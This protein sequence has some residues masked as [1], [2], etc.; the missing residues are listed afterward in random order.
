MTGFVNGTTYPY[1]TL[2]TDGT[3]VTS[4]ITDGSNFAGMASNGITVSTDKAYVVTFDLTLNSGDAPQVYFVNSQSGGATAKSNTETSVSGS[5]TITLIPTASE[6]VYLQ[7]RNTNGSSANF[8]TTAMSVRESAIKPNAARYLP[9][10]GHHVYNGS[11]W[12][13]EGLLAESE[14]RT[15]LLGHSE[16]FTTGNWN[17]TANITR[18]ADQAI[19][20]AGTET[21]DK[22]VATSTSG[23]H[24]IGIASSISS[25]SGN[26]VFSFYVKPSG[27][28]NIQVVLSN[29]TGS[30]SQIFNL[31]EGTLGTIGSGN[32]SQSIQDVGN[33]WYRC[34]MGYTSTK[35]NPYPTIRLLDDSFNST[36][37]GN[38]T[39]GIL[40][41]GGQ[42]ES[43]A[44]PSSYIPSLANTAN[45]VTRA[46]ETFTI[47]SANLPWPSPQYIGSELVSNGD[48]SNGTT[49]WE[50]RFTVTDLSVVNGALRLTED[51][52]DDSSSARAFQTITTVVGKIYYLSVDYL[53]GTGSGALFVNTSFNFGGAIAS[54]SSLAVGTHTIVFVATATTTYIILG[55]G[56]SAQY[57]DF[58]NISVR[59]I[60]P[61]SVS[62]A[63]DGRATFADTGTYAGSFPY[64]WDADNNNA[65]AALIRGDGAN[66]GKIDVEQ[67]ISGVRDVVTAG[68]IGD[69]DVLVPYKIAQRSGS[70]FL[71]GAVN[72]VEATANTTPT[73]LVDLSATDLD[74]AET[75]MGTIG[76]F[77]VWDRDIA[78]TGLVEATN[79]SLEPSLSL[80]FEGTGTNSFI[81]NDW[82]E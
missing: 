25:G 20:P 3:E 8:S 9:R 19:S 4:A 62:I 7:I 11:A 5:N 15:N 27:I 1:D 22:V 71:N 46:A 78:D 23:L 29:Q 79:P 36:F 43:G 13:N 72:G 18:T 75:Y 54:K 26:E 17:Y 31:S 12:V 47:P 63:M 66:A 77:R 52:S 34:A 60:N 68:R 58:D 64:L 14:A 74:L 53:G 48:F 32:V 82:S 44:T 59:E 28:N 10:I 51:G 45:T 30:Y 61:L 35:A 39:D 56:N 16:N 33:G 73:A 2:I 55:G 80:T 57:N 41:W 37:T 24:Y 42:L 38:D 69:P 76:T 70:T 49:N 40:L 6:T 81:V 67:K 21:A 65:V 50:K